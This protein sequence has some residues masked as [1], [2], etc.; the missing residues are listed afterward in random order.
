M[1]RD[2]KI[3]KFGKQLVWI[4]MA[5][6]MAL[7]VLTPAFAKGK[8]SYWLM[9]TWKATEEMGGKLRMYYEKDSIRLKGKARKAG[10]REKLDYAKLKKVD[11]AF[12]IAGGCKIAFVEEDGS[13]TKGR[14]KDWITNGGGGDYKEG[15][16]MW[17][18]TVL[19]K[20]RNNKIGKVIFTE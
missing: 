17:F 3:K 12:E 20:V 5:V 11:A 2:K 7:G 16:S 6:S 13:V 18:C 9:G 15:D 8:D 14:F 4:L 10:T 1:Y 19:V